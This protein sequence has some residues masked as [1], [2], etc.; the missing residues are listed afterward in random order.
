MKTNHWKR[1]LLGATAA[2]LSFPGAALAAPTCAYVMGQVDSVTVA[3]PAI[4]VFVPESGADIQP[5]RVHLD[6]EEHSIIGYSVRTPG[7]DQGVDPRKI[8]V[9]SIEHTLSP[10]VA[11][12]PQLTVLTGTCLNL[13]ASTPAVPVHIPASVFNIPGAVVD[14]PSIAL[15]ILRMPVTTPGRVIRYEGK[16]IV[17][18]AFDAMVPGVTA[19]TPD[20]SIAVD[21]NG[22]VETARY[23]APN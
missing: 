7:I 1:F 10:I 4:V 11:T 13:Q 18:P 17:I 6:E 22:T 5:V 2:A 3:T 8:F 19:G 20:Q 12:I 16:T 23:L 21:V 15:N 9:P 14:V